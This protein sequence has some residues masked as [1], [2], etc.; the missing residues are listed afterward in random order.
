MTMLSDYITDAQRLLH[1]STN[2]FWGQAELISYCNK[3]R[4]MTAALTACTRQLAAA[5]PISQVFSWQASAAHVLNDRLTP[6]PYQGLYMLCTTP[7]SSGTSSPTWPT[8]AGG[9]VVD[10]GVTWTAVSGF[11][12]SY[13]LTS[14][15]SGRQVLGALDIYLNISGLFTPPLFYLPFSDYQR[16]PAVMY[17]T[18]GTPGLWSQLNQI[19][20]IG[21]APAVSYTANI[22]CLLIPSDLVNLTD[23]DNDIPVPKDA[24]VK[25]Y[26]GYLAKLKDQRREE[27]MAFMGDFYRE[28]SFWISAEI[29]RRL[30]GQ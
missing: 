12:N 27:A 10:G 26:M 9:T 18:P 11:A 22:D 8:T 19:L 16:Q 23:V 7:G 29:Q 6:T 1:D 20:F 30:V 13:T 24:L 21:P 14:L 2:R 5:V 4:K 28:G 25:F 17:G 15:I 3:A